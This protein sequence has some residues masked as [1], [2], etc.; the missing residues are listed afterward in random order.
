MFCLYEWLW[1]KRRIVCYFALHVNI[2]FG[3]SDLFKTFLVEYKQKTQTDKFEWEYLLKATITEYKDVA[4]VYSSALLQLKCSMLYKISFN[5]YYTKSILKLIL[6]YWRYL[7]TTLQWFSK[8]I[9]TLF[10]FV[11]MS[12]CILSIHQMV[13]DAI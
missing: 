10:G 2:W 1:N 8:K 11:Y 6:N 12:C 13:F 9:C 5:I 4:I 7:F 3:S